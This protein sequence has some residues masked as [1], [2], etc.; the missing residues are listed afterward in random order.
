MITIEELEWA[1]KTLGL[2]EEATQIQIQKAFR[3]L[4][5]QNHPDRGGSPEKMSEINKAYKIIID[6]ISGYKYSL[7]E[8]ELRR[9][10][11]ESRWY[12]TMR[13]DPIWGP[14]K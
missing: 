4:S 1:R 13:N 7:T 9:Q 11:P 12:E 10:N 5:K 14:G 3:E 2:S 6:Y 8:K